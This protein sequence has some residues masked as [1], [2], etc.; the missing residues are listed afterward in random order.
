M[1][2]N[3]NHISADFANFGHDVALLEARFM[4]AYVLRTQRIP[5]HPNSLNWK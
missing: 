1:F 2:R 4:V 3:F 5:P